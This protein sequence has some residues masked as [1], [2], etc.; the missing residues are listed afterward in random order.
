M[1]VYRPSHFHQLGIKAKKRLSQNF[2]IDQNIL[3]KLCTAANIQKGD[4]ILEIGPGAGAITEK[5]LAKGAQVVAVEKDPDLA[6]K[7]SRLQNEELKIVCAD[8]L[9]FPLDNL[10]KKTK[11]VAN[12]PFHIATPLI[13]R[14]IR[15]FPKIASLTVIVQRE[16]GQR[17]TAEKNSPQYSSFS[18]FIKAYSTPKYCFSIKPTSFFPAPSVHSSVIHMPLHAFPFPFSEEAFFQMTRT[19]FGKRR[20]MLRGSLKEL[21]PKGVLEK[22]FAGANISPTARPQELTIE[23]FARLF[24]ECNPTHEN[25]ES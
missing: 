13:E 4:S 17:M 15:L 23:D 14:F 7:L 24:V 19:A 5:L 21:Y 12:L 1:P 11:V 16:V 3:D 6:E 18:L 2:L 10:P 9:N 25:T 20:K 22:G 8:A